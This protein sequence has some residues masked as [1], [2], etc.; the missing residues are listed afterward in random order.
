MQ[1]LNSKAY[2]TYKYPRSRFQNQPSTASLFPHWQKQQNIISARHISAIQPPYDLTLFSP[3]TCG[4]SPR[5]GSNAFEIIRPWNLWKTVQSRIATCCYTTRHW[6]SRGFW[7][8]AKFFLEAYRK[9]LIFS[10]CIQL[11]LVSLLCFLNLTCYFL[12]LVLMRGPTSLMI[13]VICFLTDWFWGVILFDKKPLP[14]WTRMAGWR[15][16]AAPVPW[17]QWGGTSRG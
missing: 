16:Y 1:H 2:P 11:T 7:E 5:Y 4:V 15:N 3:L 17:V 10:L 14:F 6:W 12:F 8:S 13:W 9:A